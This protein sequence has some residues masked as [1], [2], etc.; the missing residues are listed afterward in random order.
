LSR[1]PPAHEAPAATEY[2]LSSYD[3]IRR[4]G[5][6]IVDDD[7]QIKRHKGS[8]SDGAAAEEQPASWRPSE[9]DDEEYKLDGSEVDDDEEN[10]RCTQVAPVEIIFVE[11]EERVN[12]STQV[13][14]K[15]DWYKVT[16]DGVVNYI[17][18]DPID[19]VKVCVWGGICR[20]D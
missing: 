2:E 15:V 12:E 19:G 20:R 5:S 9:E 11:H 17:C 18:V 7:P 4:E 14:T 8:N 3:G 1:S 10:E 13:R 16:L 6:E